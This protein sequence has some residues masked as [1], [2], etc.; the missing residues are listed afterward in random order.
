[1]LLKINIVIWDR[2]YIGR[3]G[4]HHKQLYVCTPHGG[5]Y[6]RNVTHTMELIKQSEFESIHVLYDAV[7]KHYE[8]FANDAAGEDNEV[9]SGP[10]VQTAETGKCKEVR[11]RENAGAVKTETPRNMNVR[12]GEILMG[13]RTG[14][15]NIK[16]G[17]ELQRSEVHLGT[18]NISGIA[19][20][21]RGKYMKTEE[22]LL[23]IRPGDKLRDVTEMMK[24]Q[25]VSLMTLTDTHLSQESMTEVGNF[26]KQEGLEGGGDY[27]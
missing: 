24:T 26:L 16:E 2:R 14:K 22:E 8:Y 6:L 1:M 3:V 7:T 23:K 21:Y 18:L 11:E 15:T 17:R 13:S 12:E 25:G 4:A 5:T 10:E 27:S 19:F 20:S 9:G